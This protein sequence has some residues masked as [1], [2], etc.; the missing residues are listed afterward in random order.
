MRGKKLANIA[1]GCELTIHG[2]VNAPLKH[3]IATKIHIEIY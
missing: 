1:K 3:H 2:A